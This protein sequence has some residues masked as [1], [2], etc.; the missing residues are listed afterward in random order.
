VRGLEI[1]LNEVIMLISFTKMHEV[2]GTIF[3]LHKEG[4]DLQLFLDIVLLYPVS[5]DI[6]KTKSDFF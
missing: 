6:T 1:R 2:R 3:Y 4:F 5:L